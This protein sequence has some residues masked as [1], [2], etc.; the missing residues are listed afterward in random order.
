MLKNGNVHCACS[1][2]I[3]RTGGSFIQLGVG[4]YVAR[5]TAGVHLYGGSPKFSAIANE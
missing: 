2:I 1:V 4:A 3:W 5:V